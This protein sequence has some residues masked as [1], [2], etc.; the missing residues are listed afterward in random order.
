M[1]TNSI[2]GSGLLFLLTRP[3]A[4]SGGLP[5]CYLNYTI[6]KADPDIAGPGVLLS[7]VITCCI[8]TILVPVSFL[9]MFQDNMVNNSIDDFVLRILH[10]KFNANEDT[11]NYYT[12]ILVPLVLNL[13][14]Q[15]VV[16][17]LAILIAGFIKCDVSVYHFNIVADLG[18]LA[19]LTH[20]NAAF[21]LSN[22]LR[23]RHAAKVWRCIALLLLGVLLILALIIQGNQYW[24][25][26]TA[27]PME[28]L[29][30]FGKYSK[31]SVLWT[32]FWI[33]TTI[34]GYG[35]MI[36][37]LYPQISKGAHY[38]TNP[39]KHQVRKLARIIGVL[40]APIQN[41][42]KALES[43]LSSIT[44]LASSLFMVV[45]QTVVWLALSIYWLFNDRKNGHAVMSSDEIF[46]ENQWGFGQLVPM[47]LIVLAFISLLETWS[48]QP[49]QIS[50][51][52]TFA[53][54]T[55][56]VQ[57]EWNVAHQK[58]ETVSLD[59]P[60]EENSLESSGSVTTFNSAT[61]QPSQPT[62]SYASQVRTLR[63]NTHDVST[64]DSS[65]KVEQVNSS[66]PPDD[67]SGDI[68]SLEM[69]S[70]LSSGQSTIISEGVH[71]ISRR[72]TTQFT[73]DRA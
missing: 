51:I 13:A 48:G 63:M 21:I 53:K 18:W 67:E 36:I 72:S 65:M 26:E 54:S 33:G 14:D 28:C 4:R 62:G 11:R 10:L 73:Q 70:A 68:A 9:I 71:S 39:L 45:I 22:F 57:H 8:S 32:A 1:D 31:S 64:P 19:S 55:P 49:S 60:E 29:N 52:H 2:N 41:I 34:F 25:D 61:T 40:F 56:D 6:A 12:N 16:T 27:S 50:S 66:I 46:E 59:L 5:N 23:E 20:L 43:L 7:F 3:C 35:T 37:L 44:V 30:L 58:P 42:R 47:F 15:Q 38:L 17:G 69:R 24:S